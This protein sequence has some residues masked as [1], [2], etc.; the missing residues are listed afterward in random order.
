M[1]A[2]FETRTTE[3]S[4]LQQLLKD[5]WTIRLG[6]N[7]CTCEIN[8]KKVVGEQIPN[9]AFTYNDYVIARKSFT[10]IY[11]DTCQNTGLVTND[12]ITVDG[13]QDVFIVIGSS[14]F[15]TY[16]Y[17]SEYSLRNYLGQQTQPS[18]LVERELDAV[19]PGQI[20][21]E[22]NGSQV[23]SGIK[24]VGPVNFDLH[25]P[26]DS[27]IADKM[28]YPLKKGETYKASTGGHIMVVKL[29]QTSRVHVDFDGLRG[30]KNR[31]RK[32]VVV[33]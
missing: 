20:N 27:T 33:P 5:Y 23:T 29:N 32:R 6:S 15:T 17:D 12:T 10:G 3:M 11:E 7:P 8:G 16:E 31:M 26:Q 4:T 19:Q 1:S 21:V 18:D 24:R 28:E 14:V 25:V 13:G 9:Y 30:Y 22:I 2:Q